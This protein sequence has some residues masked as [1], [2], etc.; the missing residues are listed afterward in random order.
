M[1]RR[2]LLDEIVSKKLLTARGVS[3]FFPA[4]SVGDDIELYADASRTR[5]LATFYTLRQQMQKPDRRARLRAGRFYR[6]Q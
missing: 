4:N 2:Q 3:G 5:L 6:S 1:T